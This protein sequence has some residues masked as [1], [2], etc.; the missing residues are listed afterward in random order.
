MA[1]DQFDLQIVQRRDIGEAVPQ[2]ARERWI[3]GEPLLGAEKFFERVIRARMLRLDHAEYARG[4]RLVLDK[5][6][7]MMRDRHI[8][9]GQDHVDV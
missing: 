6:G 9:L 7:V 4:K 3:V 5:S 2:R 8:G 1:A